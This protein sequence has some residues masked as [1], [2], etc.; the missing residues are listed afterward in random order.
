MMHK[1]QIDPLGR[2]SG[3]EGSSMCELDA[4]CVVFAEQKELCKHAEAC[5]F[6]KQ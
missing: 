5:G 4:I 1:T 2:I 3:Y 6:A